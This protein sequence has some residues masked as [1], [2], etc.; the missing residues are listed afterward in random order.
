MASEWL[1]GTIRHRRKLPVQ[2]EFSYNIGM[3]AL[4]LDDWATALQPGKWDLRGV[5]YA[6]EL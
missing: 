3:L 1:E 5:I 2:H 6:R 4:D